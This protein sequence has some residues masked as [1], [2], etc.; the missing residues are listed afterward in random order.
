VGEYR[1]PAISFSE[2]GG[3]IWAALCADDSE[4]GIDA[5]GSDEFQ[6]PYPI[7]RVFHSEE[8]E[9]ALSLTGGDR[10]EALALLWSIKEAVVK[11]LG[12]GFHLVDPR[13]I[14]VY[15]LEGEAAAGDGG[16][17][18]HVVLTGKARMRFPLASARSI[19]VHSLPGRKMWLSIALVSWKP[20]RHE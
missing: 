1:G 12:C 18:F 10:E 16:H 17:T 19:R 20:T 7:Q 4:I 13:Q 11:A 9:H 6:G 14:T 2:G 3:R 15:P 5:A 8:L